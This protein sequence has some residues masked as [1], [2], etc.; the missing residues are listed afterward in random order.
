MPIIALSAL[1]FR[2]V[3]HSFCLPGTRRSRRQQMASRLGAINPRLVLGGVPIGALWSAEQQ[4]CIPL[5]TSLLP[6]HPHP[7]LA[8]QPLVY[9]IPIPRK[10]GA[11]SGR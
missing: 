2:L 8:S 4:L 10:I 6:H 1:E 11:K 3:A 7:H 5:P 9:S